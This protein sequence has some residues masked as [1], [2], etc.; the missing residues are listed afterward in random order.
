MQGNDHMVMKA[1]KQETAQVATVPAVATT[2]RLEGQ[3]E[4]VVQQKAGPGHP[5]ECATLCVCLVGTGATE[6]E[7]FLA[8]T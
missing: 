8:E 2:P 1:P 4:E 6:E 3:R 7:Q 5:A